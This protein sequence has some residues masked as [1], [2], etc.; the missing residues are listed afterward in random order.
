MSVCVALKESYRCF[1]V[2]SNIVF[3]SNLPS[4]SCYINGG[5]NLIV[6]GSLLQINKDGVSRKFFPGNTLPLWH[7]ELEAKDSLLDG[8]SAA[9]PEPMVS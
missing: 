9:S 8:F 1:L 3:S 2:E 4:K 7:E 6:L 5:R